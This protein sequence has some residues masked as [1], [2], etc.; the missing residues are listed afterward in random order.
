MLERL[1]AGEPGPRRDVVLLN[2]GAALLIAG[3]VTSLGDGIVRAAAAI[4]DGR[5]A[6]VLAGVREVSA[7]C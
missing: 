5:A 6:A 1:L 7:A 3:R 2:V 4:D